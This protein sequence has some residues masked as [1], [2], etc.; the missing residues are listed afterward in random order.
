M[1]EL[2]IIIDDFKKRIN[3]SEKE[4][5]KNTIGRNCKSVLMFGSLRDIF[6][7]S[8]IIASLFVNFTPVTMG[9]T[10]R[11]F[12]LLDFKN[13][14]LTIVNASLS[15]S[16]LSSIIILLQIHFSIDKSLLKNLDKNECLEALEY[17]INFHKTFE[18]AESEYK[19]I[20]ENFNLYY[21]KS[22]T[23]KD[24]ASLS[25]IDLDLF[26]Y[27]EFKIKNMKKQ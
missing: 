21:K 3:K 14:I 7:V 22:D 26:N 18:K 12:F 17:H 19:I 16:F 13:E 24:K 9:E 5:Q 11:T 25:K 23:L 20:I 10:I 8:F 27:L 6:L 1:N 15:L 2:K 4:N